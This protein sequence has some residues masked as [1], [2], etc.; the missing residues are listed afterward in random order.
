MSLLKSETLMPL[1]TQDRLSSPLLLYDV[2]ESHLQEATISFAHQI[3]RFSQNSSTEKK[4]QSGSHPD[5]HIFQPEGKANLYS[6]ETVQSFIKESSLPP[7][8]SAYA[9]YLFLQAE[10]MLPVHANALLK[11]LEEKRPFAAILLATTNLS[12]ILPTIQSR[13]QKIALSSSSSTLPTHSLLTTAFHQSLTKQY[14]SLIKTIELIEKEEIPLSE[15]TTALL[16]Y[17]RDLFILQNNLPSHLLSHTDLTLSAN[18]SPSLELLSRRIETAHEAQDRNIKLK[19]I[20]EFLLL[21]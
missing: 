12:S 3:L 20:L 17:H 16:Q 18:R 10:R 11:T 6:M 8:E 2:E 1:I 7:L 4:I 9:V 19:H 5:L 14:S 15:I 21:S 13:C